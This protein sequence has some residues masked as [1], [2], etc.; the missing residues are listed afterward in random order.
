[1][2][3][4][5]NLKLKDICEEAHRELVLKNKDQ[6]ILA[7]QWKQLLEGQSM[8]ENWTSNAQKKY[9]A[10]WRAIVF[11]AKSLEWDTLEEFS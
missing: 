11:V 1:M 6:K 10:N 5:F 3:D 2:S 4:R 9:L 8:T 7:F